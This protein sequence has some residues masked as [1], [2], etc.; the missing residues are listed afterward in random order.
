M[1]R[2][3]RVGADLARATYVAT[4]DAGSGSAVGSSGVVARV[5]GAT[6]DSPRPQPF[7][8]TVAGAPLRL[9]AV[10]SM[11]GRV[12]DCT[13]EALPSAND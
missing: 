12:V 11:D 13:D 8:Y 1:G 2:P 4:L 3:P 6:G 9:R 5:V 10:I 7:A